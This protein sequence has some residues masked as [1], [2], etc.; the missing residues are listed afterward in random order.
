MKAI[1]NLVRGVVAYVLLAVAT[2]PA[3]ALLNL[4]AVPAS[5]A[6]VVSSIEVRGN[7][8]VDD[9][10]II[11][12]VGIRPGVS[13]SNADVDAGVKR[14]FS[15]GLFSDV[16][17]NQVVRTLVIVVEEYAIVNQV[18]FQGNKKLKD[19]DLARVVQLKPRGTFS[20]A[21]LELDEQAIRDAYE[22]IGRSD[23]VVTSQVIDLGENRKNVLFQ[24]TEGGRTKIAE[25]N[26]VGNK[27]FS[28]RRL[29]GVISTKKSNLFSFL[30]REDVYDADRLRADEEALRR[31]Y[32][33]RGYADFR[34]I[35]STADLDDSNNEYRLTITVDEG[36]RYRFGSI[37]I[38]STVGGIDGESLRYLL[39]TH[40]GDVYSAKDVED[41]LVALTEHMSGLGYVF[42]QV[43]PRGNRD[44]D[45]RTIAVVFSIDQG[46]RTYI[47]RIEIRGNT[48][49]R[50][51]VIR[52]EFDI[53]EGDAFNRILVQRAKR[54]LEDLKFFTSVNI[55]TVPGSEPDQ[56]IMIVDVKEKATGEF[57][58][59]AGYSSGGLNPGPSV[60][61]GITERNFLGRGQ[62][63]RV[64]V[65]GGQDNRTYQVSF[66]EPYFLGRRISAGF[67]IYR[68]TRNDTFYDQE[69]TG[70][71]VRFGLPITE[72]L[73]G[74]VA[75]N[76]S[77]QSYSYTGA[78]VPPTC[79]G[80][81][82]PLPAC[83]VPTAIQNAVVISPWVKSSLS[84]ALLYNSLDDPKL[85][86]SGLYATVGAEFA[87]IGG[88]A[89]FI[90]LTGR[91]SYYRTLLD[92][93]DV[94]GV[95]TVGAG[96]V[97]SLGGGGIS[98]FDVFQANSR[99][100]RG[101]EHAGF[102]PVSVATGEHVGGTTYFHGSVEAQFPVPVLP[103]TFGVRAA[104]FA[105]A[106]T[107]YNMPAAVAMEPVA[108]NGSAIR[109]SV[110]AGIIWDSP[111]GPLRIDY[112]IPV[113]KQPTD[114][115]QE[116]NFGMTSQF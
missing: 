32:Y 10:T 113:Q 16:R 46:A 60:E 112:A 98:I 54:R 111:F 114:N 36:D 30:I 65:G 15:T 25:I 38:E 89:R 75:Y 1:G 64:S 43:T 95:V 79:P 61:I 55:S 51:Y 39:E 80:A 59:G 14:L 100:V 2:I 93:A 91:A 81:P 71:T 44:F 56:I 105:D 48:R 22:R 7:Q 84:T 103:E 90:K 62:Y 76:Y 86:H 101:F 50:D 8:R 41:S 85:P 37:E 29:A 78:A 57:S 96:H 70:A 21:T 13:F 17:I 107:L 72:E 28:D 74:Q 73:S 12:Y 11:N 88:S 33:N 116:F 108:S 94:V 34:I 110:G 20:Q 99:I 3:A 115:V 66:T 82:G 97:A 49:T 40:E 45:T 9:E 104:V 109:A 68:N 47:Q 102:G 52:R 77:Q 24:I 26:F 92:E 35:S 87:G 53:A 4:V 23:A 31:F 67:D 58:I 42:A 6:A 106:G 83:P 69:A 19:D 5:H 18:L 27:A 63:I